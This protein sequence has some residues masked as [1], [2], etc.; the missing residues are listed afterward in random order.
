MLARSFSD[1]VDSN[2]RAKAVENTVI[3]PTPI[4]QSVKAKPINAAAIKLVAPTNQARQTAT[5][6]VS[7][8]LPTPPTKATSKPTTIT[9]AVTPKPTPVTLPKPVVKKAA[10]IVEITPQA[11][12]TAAA[13]PPS[14]PVS[15]LKS[16]S[17]TPTPIVTPMPV[18]AEV[19]TP[20]AKPIK[21]TIAVKAVTKLSASTSAK[22]AIKA[23]DEAG[24]Q[25]ITQPARAAV[26]EVSEE[27]KGYAKIVY[28]HIASK[29]QRKVRGKGT[30][31]I[32]FKLNTDGSIAYAKIIKSSG[33]TR[34]DK[35]ALNHVKR[36]APFPK[37]PAHAGLS[38]TLPVSI[39]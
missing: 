16:Q 4:S 34:V 6:K 39:R 29:P 22:Q 27:A 36:A 25:A 10:A 8:P 13:M 28:Q 9:R 12:T 18:T 24:E 38:F 33:R 3:K 11:T 7:K 26:P 14:P 17:V 32:E 15:K 31:T 2:T 35:A 5:T 20:N 37:P 1:L 23:T 30:V 19:L 21:Q